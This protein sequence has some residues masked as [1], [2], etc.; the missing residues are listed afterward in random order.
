MIRKLWDLKVEK[1]TNAVTY[2]CFKL[3]HINII[4]FLIIIFNLNIMRLNKWS[5]FNYKNSL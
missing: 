1:L 3:I 5:V 4:E 2:F